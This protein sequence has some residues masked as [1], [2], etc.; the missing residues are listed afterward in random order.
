MPGPAA[1]RGDRARRGGRT[2]R[3]GARGRPRAVY[4]T[5]EQLATLRLVTRLEVGD[6][7]ARYEA[8]RPSGD[9]HHHL[10]CDD[11]GSVAPFEDA[12]LERA[13][14]RLSGRLRIAVDA[15]DVTLRGVCPRCRQSSTS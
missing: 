9:H 10:V 13:I 14:R 3:E 8:A 1:L 12:D 11:C 5:L 6:G 2:A 7:T 4:R 15:D